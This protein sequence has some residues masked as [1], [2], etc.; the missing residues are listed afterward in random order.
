MATQR[1][2]S[3][4][5]ALK[6]LF[7]VGQSADPRGIS[8]ADLGRITGLTRPTLYR[9]LGELQEF[10]LVT[11]VPKQPIWQLG[12]K[13]IALAAMAGNWAV[14]RRR[15]RVAMD[16]F[17]RTVGYTV[18]LG[19]RDGT[20]VVYVDKA[21]SMEGYGI[22]SAIGQRK[23]LHVTALGKCLVAFDADPALAEKIA[24]SGLAPRTPYSITDSTRWLAEIEAVRRMGFAIDNQE[25]E[26]GAR[27]VAAPILDAQRFAVAAI[28]LSTL[29]GRS[30]DA[31]FEHLS[32]QLREV[33]HNI[34]L[35]ADI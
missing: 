20:Q 32:H 17:V 8:V 21:E 4:G 33:A 26:L 12:P 30:N 13:V 28:S 35:A 24:L 14:L 10:G 27:C 19:V 2:T 15:A 31:E 18:H 16:E 11:S 22:A 5:K 1:D 9:F 29:I 3:L 7:A 25:S 23:G 34:G 6:L